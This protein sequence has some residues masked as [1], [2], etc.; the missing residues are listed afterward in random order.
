MLSRSSLF[1]PTPGSP[2]GR[3]RGTSQRPGPRLLPNRDDR[4]PLDSRVRPLDPPAHAAGAHPDAARDRRPAPLPRH[5]GVQLYDRTGSRRRR[6]LD[7]CLTPHPRI[8]ERGGVV[9]PAAM[10]LRG[11]NV[12]H[13]VS[14][15]GAAG[16]QPRPY[17]VG[18]LRQAPGAA[19]GRATSTPSS[20]SAAA[21]WP[22]PPAQPCRVLTPLVPASSGRLRWSY[23]VTRTPTC[24]RRTR[25]A[26]RQSYPPTTCTRRCGPTSRV[27]KAGWRRRCASCCRRRRGWRSTRSPTQCGARSHPVPSRRPRSWRRPSWR[28][29]R[30]SWPAS[31]RRSASTSSP[32]SRCIPCSARHPSDRPQR[33]LP[34]PPL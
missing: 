34:S 26:P 8:E 12:P 18:P 28:R 2:M 15:R 4:L 9:H 6:R 16:A 21:T 29:R 22:T 7:R 5:P 33:L 32:C 20:S 10:I 30:T 23:Q 11:G 14:R 27:A 13:R 19:R 24:S 17:A 1:F 31:A 25:R 3:T